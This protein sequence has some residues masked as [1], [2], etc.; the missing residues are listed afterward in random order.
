MEDIFVDWLL[1]FAMLFVI[2]IAVIMLLMVL[3]S[4]VSNIKTSWKS[5]AGFGALLLLAFI[6]YGMGAGELKESWVEEFGLTKASS[7][8][9][10]GGIYLAIAMIILTAIAA[11]FTGL[12]S[13]LRNTFNF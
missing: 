13:W 3:W 12:F 1:P 5:L 2:I 10:D 11:V 4:M 9:V 6:L 8:L 7:K